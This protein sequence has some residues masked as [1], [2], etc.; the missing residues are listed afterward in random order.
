M[1]VSIHSTAISMLLTPESTPRVNL[2]WTIS[3]VERLHG[4]VVV[5]TA[6]D[7]PTKARASS[8]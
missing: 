7:L 3:R 4:C 2:N 6:S 1:E 5:D 8:R